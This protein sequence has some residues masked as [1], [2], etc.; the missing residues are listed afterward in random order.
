M[1]HIDWKAFARLGEPIVKEFDEP[2]RLRVLIQL[3]SCEQSEVES[4]WLFEH[5]LGLTSALACTPGLLTQRG[6]GGA[7]VQVRADDAAAVC[8]AFGGACRGA[9]RG[10]GVRACVLGRPTDDQRIRDLHFA[11]LRYQRLG[12]G[13]IETEGLDQ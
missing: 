11:Q 5:A 3:D 12:L 1:R 10:A 6:I 7:V 2:S 9:C 8:D 13:Y 4:S